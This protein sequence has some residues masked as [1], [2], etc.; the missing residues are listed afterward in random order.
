VKNSSLN[1]N[2]ESSVEKLI[3][4]LAISPDTYSHLQVFLHRVIEKKCQYDYE[5]LMVTPTRFGKVEVLNLNVEG[6]FIIIEFRDCA[7]G[8]TG[9]VRIN[10]ND[11]NPKMLFICWQ[12]ITK[13]V[14]GV[15]KPSYCS[16]ELLELDY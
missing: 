14:K 2:P 15:N 13:M 1:S 7:L 12:D 8:K 3:N 16:D 9:E 10:I 6:D 4:R 11:T 5:F